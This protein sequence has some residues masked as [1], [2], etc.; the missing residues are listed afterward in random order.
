MIEKLVAAHAAGQLTFY[1]A[2]AALVT[3][4]AFAAYLLYGGPRRGAAH[5]T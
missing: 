5:T 4:K 1:G 3:S 2:H